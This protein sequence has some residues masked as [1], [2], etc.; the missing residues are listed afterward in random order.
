M[1]NEQT[2]G[3]QTDPPAMQSLAGHLLA[4]IKI[5]R[6]NEELEDNGNHHQ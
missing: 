6:D 4:I 5:L 1:K 2:D 3:I